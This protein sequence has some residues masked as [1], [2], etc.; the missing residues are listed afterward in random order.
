MG[1]GAAA[2]PTLPAF[3]DLATLTLK[4]ASDLVTFFGPVHNPWALDHVP[5]G[6]SGGSLNPEVAKAV[7]SAIDV[8]RKLAEAKLFVLH[9]RTC[10]ELTTNR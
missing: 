8:L 9:N 2:S 10:G 6:S 7:E 3:P 5:G 4:Q 1:V